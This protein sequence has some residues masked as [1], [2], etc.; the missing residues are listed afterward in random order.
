MR[1]VLFVSW[2]EE[3]QD[4]TLKKKRKSKKYG[5][6]KSRPLLTMEFMITPIN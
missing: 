4:I 1:T 5:R 6:G 2:Q 3:I